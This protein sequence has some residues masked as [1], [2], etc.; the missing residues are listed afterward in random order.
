MH[1]HACHDT[2]LFPCYYVTDMR[3]FGTLRLLF[4]A[5]CP[6]APQSCHKASCRKTYLFKETAN[7]NVHRLESMT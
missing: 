2:S 6:K 1:G 7:S 3:I 5:V 4:K